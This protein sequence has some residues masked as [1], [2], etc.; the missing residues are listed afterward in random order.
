MLT[1]VLTVEE[2]E[3]NG[4]LDAN[5]TLVGLKANRREE[6]M[7][8]GLLKAIERYCTKER[9]PINGGKFMRTEW[10]FE[11]NDNNKRKQ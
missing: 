6:E 11:N 9:M 3:L 4:V 2:D 10:P 5:G 8:A 1:F 7:M